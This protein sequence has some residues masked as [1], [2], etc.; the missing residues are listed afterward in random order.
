MAMSSDREGSRSAC[1]GDPA[2]AQQDSDAWKKFKRHALTASVL[3]A[4]S[5]ILGL[6]AL[7]IKSRNGRDPTIQRLTRRLI[8]ASE[9]ERRH[10]AREL[11]DD[12]GQRLSL[13]SIQLGALQR[14]RGADA[15][16]CEE[17]LADSLRELD[18]LIEDVHNLSHNLHS[19]KLEHLGLEAAL[20]GVCTRISQRH[21]LNVEVRSSGV[22]SDLNPDTALCFYRVAQEA[23]SNVV[24]H[25]ESSRALVCL[26]GDVD[27]IAMQVIDFGIGF[28]PA[29]SAGLGLATME[30]RVLA[31]S[32]RFSIASKPGHGTTIAAEAPLRQRSAAAEKKE[33]AS[34]R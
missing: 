11:H 24:K 16:S 30:E 10:I 20:G 1:A 2:R 17:D 21:S 27:C 25:S 14:Q 4:Q 6:F 32:G 18:L 34:Q 22:P 23:L 5:G 28:E 13:I 15:C 8:Q 31:I 29:A 9:D 3:L 7:I 26:A 33:V 19:A 12:I